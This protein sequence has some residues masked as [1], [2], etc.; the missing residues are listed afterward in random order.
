MVFHLNDT[1]YTVIR[2]FSQIMVSKNTPT[3][4]VLVQGVHNSMVLGVALLSKE[5]LINKDVKLIKL[6]K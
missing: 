6:I 1:K 4:T 3:F 5:N 2:M